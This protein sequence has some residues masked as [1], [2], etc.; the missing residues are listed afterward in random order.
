MKL[1]NKVAIVTG[2]SSGIGKAIAL[3]FAREGADIAVGYNSSRD[4]AQSVAEQIRA[5]GR[6]AITFQMDV[7]SMEDAQR[8]LDMTMNAF[9]KVD[10]LVNN[11]GARLPA[12]IDECPPE[13][14]RRCVDSN[15]RGLFAAVK[16]V[17]PIM[18]KNGGG[19][20]INI[21]S[22]SAIRSCYQDRIGYCSTKRGIEAM[23]RA[24]AVELGPYRIFVNS[25]APGTIA[26]NMGGYTAVFT[27]E[28]V[29]ERNKWIPLRCRGTTDQMIG[30][31][32]FL[33]SADSDYVTGTCMVVDGGWSVSE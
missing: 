29:K 17:T 2:A 7:A 24:M 19:K 23:T 14:Y 8:F 3:G 22:L 27:E 18:I 28:L 1:E 15:L 4:K 16:A 11:A 12:A 26:T 9:G 33:A 6:R 13:L 21:S 20:I 32:V 31:A 25:I 10:I 30:P 5:M